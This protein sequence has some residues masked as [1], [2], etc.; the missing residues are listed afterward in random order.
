LL[1]AFARTLADWTGETSV[2]FITEG[3]GRDL[4]LPGVDISRTVGW[5]TTLYPLVLDI[6]PQTTPEFLLE[7]VSALASSAADRAVSYNLLRFLRR[8]AGLDASLQVSFNYLGRFDAAERGGF[9]PAQESKGPERHPDDHRPHLIDFSA[10]LVDDELIV[11]WHYS[12]AH[13]RSETI[14]RLADAFFSHL[15]D[16]TSGADAWSSDDFLDD[17]L[18]DDLL[19][20]LDV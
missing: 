13:H 12:T 4:E 1:A 17:E 15:Q 10:S 14:Q 6:N 5:F 11:T 9:A 20:E 2:G 3:H 7:D 18:L 16:F 19:D 8:E